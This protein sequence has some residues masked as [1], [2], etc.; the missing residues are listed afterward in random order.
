MTKPFDR[1]S[2]FFTARAHYF[3]THLETQRN[4]AGDNEEV[5]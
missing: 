1:V 5:A 3:Q 4:I 2:D